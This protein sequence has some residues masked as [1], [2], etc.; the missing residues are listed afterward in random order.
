MTPHSTVT[1][2]R[3]TH[4]VPLQPVILAIALMLAAPGL[5]TAQAATKAK[6]GSNRIITET[7]AEAAGE[8]PSQRS[9]H[10]RTVSFSLKQLGALFPLQLRGIRGNSGVTFSIRADQVVTGAKLKINYA[11]SPA[12]IPQLSH[13]NVLVNEQVAATIPVPTEQA[14]QN[15][16]REIVIPPRLITEFNRLNLELIGHYTRDCEDPAH[17]SLWANVGNDSTLELTLTPV[18]QANDL[19]LLPQP[20]FDRRD[21]LPL[22]LPMVFAGAPSGATLEAAGALSSWFGALA[23]YRGAR[24]P[25]LQDQIPAQGN[26]IVLAMGNQVPGGL[27]VSAL[28]GPTVA[29]VPNPNDP[30]AK[31]LLVMGRDAK[32]LKIAANA[33]AVGSP[34]LSGPVATITSLSE[35]KPRKP[36]DAPNWLASDR[37]VKFGE[38]ALEDTLNV[39]GYSPDLIRVNF[40]LPP[41]LFGWRSK[42]IPVDLKYRYTPRLNTD[43]STLNISA[44]QQFLRSLPLLAINHDAPSAL[45]RAVN[46][47]VP[48]GELIPAREQF[49]IPLFKLPARAQL[50]FHYFHDMVKQGACKDVVLENVRGTVEPD[51]TIDISSFPHFL[52]MPDLA[53]FSNSGFPFTRLADLSETAIVMPDKPSL[54]DYSSYLSLLGVFGRSTGY[55]ATAVSVVGPK[56]VD[57]LAGKDVVVIGSGNNQPLLAQWADASPVGMQGGSRRF[58]L[59]DFAYRV[60]SWWDPSQRDGAKPGRNQ[61]AFTADSTDGVIAGFESPVSPGRSVV[62]LSSNNPEGLSQVIEALLDP[63]LVKEIQGS[64]S[65]VRGKQVDS[66]VAEQTYWVGRLDPLTWV[67]WYLSRSPLLLLALGIVAALL[68]GVLLFLSLRARARA[69]LKNKD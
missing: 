2:K 42:G 52:A 10:A 60:F 56:Q 9:S 47:V 12:L 33:V 39:A 62:Q 25:A 20:F 24:F 35:I 61:V 57:A 14:G 67:Q 22:N 53:A 11:Y 3:S 54:N 13:I 64:T 46:A 1:S 36:Y 63:D 27:N 4:R 58:N 69:R 23:G 43:K 31:L 48:P 26:A 19:A 45:D 59:S 28:Q 38:L 66:L 65:V 5:Q 55:P 8:T 50:Q 34:A 40:H 18:A 51:S 49:H 41:D 32:E 21:A 68:I 30:S 37:P 16:Q 15:L 17:S 29:M 7:A 6:S 44:N